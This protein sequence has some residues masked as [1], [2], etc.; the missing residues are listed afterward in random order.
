MNNMFYY[1]QYLTDVIL[2]GWET[3][4]L[5]T[6]SGVF[7]NC[8]RLAF[9]DIRDMTF[10]SVPDTTSNYQNMFSSSYHVNTE[11]IVK[12]ETEKAWLLE[13]FSFLTGVKTLAEYEAEL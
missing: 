10:D 6:V 5:R 12:G 4:K 2:K 9:V 8:N 1:D 13:R 3:P 11:I 7:S